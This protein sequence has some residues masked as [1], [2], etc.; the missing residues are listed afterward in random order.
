MVN[1][2]EKINELMEGLHSFRRRVA[3]G[4]ANC[5][6]APRITP[7]QWGALML[8]EQG[9]GG[10][11]KDIA[12][13]LAISSSAATQLVDGLVASG[14]VVR[15]EDPKDHRR[16]ALLLSTKTKSHVAKMKK[17]V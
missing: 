7:S 2:K 9:T 4:V 1:R 11:V 8:I 3:P 12:T 5:M 15:K 13:A 14:Y 10:T 16:I 17:R 6:S